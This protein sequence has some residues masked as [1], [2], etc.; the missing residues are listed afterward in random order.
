M[1]IGEAKVLRGEA[2]AEDAQSLPRAELLP[3]AGRVRQLRLGEVLLPEFSE[4]LRSRMHYISARIKGKGKRAM[5][6]TLLAD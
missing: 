2:Q 1:A 3:R 4:N 5:S 6:R